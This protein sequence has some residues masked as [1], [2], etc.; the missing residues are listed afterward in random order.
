[1]SHLC[2]LPRCHAN[3]QTFAKCRTLLCS[4]IVYFP[5]LGEFLWRGVLNIGQLCCDRL[6]PTHSIT[7]LT[8]RV[9]HSPGLMTWL[10]KQYSTILIVAVSWPLATVLQFVSWMRCRTLGQI[11]PKIAYLVASIHRAIHRPGA[12][13]FSKTTDMIIFSQQNEPHSKNFFCWYL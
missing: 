11:L 5:N 6:W 1:M 9:L 4:S 12:S 2:W 7:I 8:W 3:P 10:L 13:K